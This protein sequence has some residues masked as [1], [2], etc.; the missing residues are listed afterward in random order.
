MPT[1]TLRLVLRGLQLLHHLQGCLLQGCI[2]RH[3]Q[4][5][6]TP[7]VQHYHH[8][9]YGSRSLAPVL[10]LVQP[11]YLGYFVQSSYLVCCSDIT[12]IDGHV[13]NSEQFPDKGG[14][15]GDGLSFKGGFKLGDPRGDQGMAG[16]FRSIVPSSSARGI[17]SD[18]VGLTVGLRLI[19]AIEGDEAGKVFLLGSEAGN[20]IFSAA[21]G[22]IVAQ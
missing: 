4:P 19:E 7:M 11:E 15:I 12:R 6:R 20:G 8:L 3:Y 13:A 18:V 1:T 5:V 21:H 17:G 10:F 14:G 9:G 22:E 16:E 2:R